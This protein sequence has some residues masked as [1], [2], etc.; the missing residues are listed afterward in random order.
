MI[1]LGT[2]DLDTILFLA[3]R[4]ALPRHTYVTVE[5]ADLIKK[6][7][8]ILHPGTLRQISA[9]IQKEIVTDKTMWQ[10]DQIMWMGVVADIEQYLKV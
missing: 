6:Y 8:Q 5:V 4:Y 10:C 9:E 2:E 3:F 1:S 7:I